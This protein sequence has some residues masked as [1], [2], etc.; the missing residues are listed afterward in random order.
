DV[1]PDPLG[2]RDPFQAEPTK[3]AHPEAKRP[4]GD[5][6]VPLLVYGRRTCLWSGR[7]LRLA[8][9][10]DIEPV[11]VALDRPGLEHLE[12]QLVSGTKHN[13]SPWV[14]LRGTF[15]GGYGSLE[16]IDRMGQLDV[17]LLPV[18]EREARAKASGMR[19]QLPP[20]RED[21]G[22]PR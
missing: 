11:F 17:M 22:A 4:I 1:I 13:S 6:S 10:R 15:V 2:L 14:Y 7:V 19:I 8:Q 21:P 3:A 5:P 9:D 12:R 18:D 20:P 16:G